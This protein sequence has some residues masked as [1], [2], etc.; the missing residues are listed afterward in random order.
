M[1]LQQAKQ[2]D[3]PNTYFYDTSPSLNSKTDQTV[4]YVLQDRNR[5]CL[6]YEIKVKTLPKLAAL[7][8]D[9][10]GEY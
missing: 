4:A 2:Q 7:D 5:I 9:L 8:C 6:I 1:R 3:L 10:I